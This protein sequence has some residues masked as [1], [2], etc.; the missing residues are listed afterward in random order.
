MRGIKKKRKKKLLGGQTLK[1]LTSLQIRQNTNR[2]YL[3]E[4]SLT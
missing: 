3:R 2:H 1:L 4:E